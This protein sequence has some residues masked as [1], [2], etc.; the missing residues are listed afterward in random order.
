[1]QVPH[2]ICNVLMEGTNLGGQNNKRLWA[3]WK[4]SN[5]AQAEGHMPRSICA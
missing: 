4:T 5:G 2:Q 1:M 3:T